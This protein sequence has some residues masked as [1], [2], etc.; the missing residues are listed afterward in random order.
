MIKSKTELFNAVLTR[1]GEKR[2]NDSNVTDASAVVL[3]D[4][5]QQSVDEVLN[6]YP[7]SCATSRAV[8][9][10][11][12]GDNFTGYQYKY[13]IPAD[14]LQIVSLLDA[15]EYFPLTD[16]YVREGRILYTDVPNVAV[17]YTRRIEFYDMDT[18]VQNMLVFMLAAKSA[19]RIT[20]NADLEQDMLAQYM[21]AKNEAE[22]AD[23]YEKK[24]RNVDAFDRGWLIP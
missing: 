17:K 12:D 21:I 11:L 5:Y 15:E 14:C 3:R 8:L 16:D 24:N 2:I 18:L 10:H 23:G 6:S 13:Q 7:W 19:Y 1:L 22:F 20:Q 9:A 4:V